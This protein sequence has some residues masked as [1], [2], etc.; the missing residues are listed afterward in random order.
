MP[1]SHAARAKIDEKSFENLRKSIPNRPQIKEKSIL[2]WF[3][4]PRSFRGRTRTRSRRCLDTQMTPQGRSGDAPG[5]PRVPRSRQ[6]ALPCRPRDAPRASLRAF[7]TDFSHDIGKHACRKARGTNFV[8][9]F[10]F[11]VLSRDGSDVHETSVLMV[12][13]HDCSMFA[14]H[15][16]AHAG[17]L[18][19]QQLR[20]RKSSQGGPKPLQGASGR[21]K[22]EPK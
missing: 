17:S 15:K 9:F 7:G 13:Q 4:R 16:C 2:G 1:S 11:R 19:K 3:G 8:P 10:V 14:S 18:K 6:K 20:P 12:F 22:I 21:T 5:R